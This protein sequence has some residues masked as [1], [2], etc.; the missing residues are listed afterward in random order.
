MCVY[1]VH[2]R[3][4]FIS[5]VTC[6]SFNKALIDP[7]LQDSRRHEGRSKRKECSLCNGSAVILAHGLI[8]RSAAR[9]GRCRCC[10][11]CDNQLE[12]FCSCIGRCVWAATCS[13]SPPRSFSSPGGGG[14]RQA[15]PPPEG[16]VRSVTLLFD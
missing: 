12:P 10:Y 4:S 14:G 15:V 2:K 16:R 3:I 5:S 1:S 7:S 13:H 8:H 6:G 11:M 9:G